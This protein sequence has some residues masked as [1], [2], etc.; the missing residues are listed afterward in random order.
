M[1]LQR[2][3]SEQHGHANQLRAADPSAVNRRPYNTLK[4]HF[5]KEVDEAG[6]AFGLAMTDIVKVLTT[7]L[8]LSAQSNSIIT[9]KLQRI[10][11]WATAAS[12]DTLRPSVK[13]EVS[14]LVPTLADPATAGSAIVHYPLLKILQD[15][16][17]VSKAARVSYSW[18]LAMRDI[19]LTENSNFVVATVAANTKDT[20]VYIHVQWSTVDVANPIPDPLVFKFD[21]E[22]DSASDWDKDVHTSV[23]CLQ[24]AATALTLTDA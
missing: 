9:V 23:A 13:V 21:D 5:V 14:S 12:G 7:Q 11:C 24:C 18:P 20:D 4:L 1:A 8:G 16:G 19:P 15:N 22:D 10:D 6:I 17:S 2:Y 3:K